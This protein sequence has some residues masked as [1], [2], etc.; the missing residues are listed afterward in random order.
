MNII[1]L[2]L[3]RDT[4]KAELTE[5]FEQYGPVA[6]CDIVMD[7]QTGLSKGFGFI[8]MNDEDEAEA[9]IISL[10]GIELDGY[11]IRVKTST[12]SQS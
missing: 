7:K 4:T 6:S 11:K 10:H 12:K 3:S 5:L 2:N 1:I 8:Q 9:A